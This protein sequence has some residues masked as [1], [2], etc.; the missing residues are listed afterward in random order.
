MTPLEGRLLDQDA[1]RPPF[2]VRLKQ[3]PGADPDDAGFWRDP[4]GAVHVVARAGAFTFVPA[5]PGVVLDGV[6]ALVVPAD[7]LVSFLIRPGEG[8]DNTFLL[9]EACDQACVMC[10]QPP[11]PVHHARWD[12]LRTAVRLAPPDAII[13]LT[14]GEPL[15]LKGALFPWLAACHAE[16]PDVAFHLLTNAQRLEPG[17][18]SVLRACAGWVLWGVPLYGPDA[19]SHDPVVGKAGAWARLLPALNLL[20]QTGSAV[21]LRTVLMASTVPVMARLADFVV[22]HLSWIEVWALMRLEAQG[23]AREAW[24]TL[25]V[26][27]ED[28]F[29]PVAAALRQCETAGVAAVLYNFPRC[30]IPE[31]WRSWAVAS[32]SD[33]KRSY[34]PECEGCPERGPCGGYFSSDPVFSPL[35]HRA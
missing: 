13:G 8:R 18:A 32:I 29:A 11:R 15:L 3:D 17:D 20:A 31:A 33:W 10:A 5:D 24:E 23:F 34:P 26:A 6:V 27:G 28:G 12:L 1:T 4:T 21:E 9:T 2:V 25:S 19:A 35:E 30:T 16:R 14:G 7:G 22:R